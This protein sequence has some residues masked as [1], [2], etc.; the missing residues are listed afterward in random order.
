VAAWGVSK[1]KKRRQGPLFEC[2]AGKCLMLRFLSE[3][4]PS[5]CD[6]SLY[7]LDVITTHANV[8]P[9]RAQTIAQF[10]LIN[11]ETRDEQ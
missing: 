10:L 6:N 8:T 9:L 1:V 2:D 7:L 5:I 11:H 4:L 3:E